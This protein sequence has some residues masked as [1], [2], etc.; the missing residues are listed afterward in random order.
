MQTQHVSNSNFIDMSNF[1][2]KGPINNTKSWFSNLPNPAIYMNAST[3]TS[4]YANQ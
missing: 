3:I 1:L 2:D 4:E